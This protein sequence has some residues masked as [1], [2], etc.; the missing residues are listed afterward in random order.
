MFFEKKCPEFF[1]FLKFEDNFPLKRDKKVE[2][3]VKI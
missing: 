1:E 3:N 2:R